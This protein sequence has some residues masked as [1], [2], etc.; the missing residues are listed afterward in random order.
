MSAPQHP[1]SPDRRRFLA[2]AAVFGAGAATAGLWRPA[3]A[4]AGSAPAEWQ[5]WSGS[6]KARPA[7]GLLYPTTEAELAQAVRTATGPIRAVGGSHSFSPVVA[8]NGTLISLEA[9]NGLVRHDAGALTATFRAGTRI[10]VIGE[11]LKQVGQ[12]LINEA[13][14]N[15]QSLG[16]AVSTSTHGTG[17][18]LQSYSGY[19]TGLRLVTAG[20]DILEVSAERDRALFD[21]ARVAVGSLGVLSEIT[22]QNRAAYR[23]RETV[24][25]M[26]L[27]AAITAIEQ[28]RDRHRHMEFFAF[29]FGGKAI[30]KRMDITTDAATPVVVED[31]NRLLEF[32]A[33]TARKFPWTNPWIQRLV[34]M[35]ITDSERVGDSYAVFASPRTV[36]FNEMEYTVPA[37]RGLECLQEV[38]ETIRR[39]GINVFFPIEFRY[40]AAD[41]TMLSPFAGRAG[42]SIS[43][44]QYY[45]QDYQP[46]FRLV[47][48]I[49]WKYQGRPHW[50]KLHTLK[51][52]NL[53]AVY[54]RFDEFLR[55]RRELDPKGR[56]LNAHAQAL[57]LG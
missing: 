40:T 53:R 57:F 42:A 56:F 19:V 4:R 17:R 30:V 36:G 47:E 1:T 35:F 28:G 34:G 11:S 6:Q 15:M 25:V 12:A 55:L 48:P 38:V 14:I 22:L 33:D 18:T 8:S 32:A 5:N 20:G 50:G 26:D 23:L 52:R 29:P 27:P 24:T 3:S 54:P 7:G 41:D 51:A 16:G 45:K 49:F 9:L 37:E 44:H 10:F 31:D 13:D 39:A 2:Q 46:L 43:V 21:A